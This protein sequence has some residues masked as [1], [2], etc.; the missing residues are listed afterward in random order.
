[1]FIFNF[2]MLLLLSDALYHYISPHE[3][4]TIIDH[5]F[6]GSATKDL[7]YERAIDTV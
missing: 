2:I 7:P 3:G 5:D 6:D 4:G 1:M